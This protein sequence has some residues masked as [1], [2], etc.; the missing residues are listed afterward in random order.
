MNGRN[1]YVHHIG[2][3]ILRGTAQEVTSVLFWPTEIGMSP[4]IVCFTFI[5]NSMLQT[6]IHMQQLI[7]KLVHCCLYIGCT[8]VVSQLLSPNHETLAN[9]L[10]VIS[11]AWT[12]KQLCHPDLAERTPLTFIPPLSEEWVSHEVMVIFPGDTI[13]G[14][15]SAYSMP[16]F[17]G[18]F[19]AY[20]FDSSFS[21]QTILTTLFVNSSQQ[22]VRTYLCHLGCV[23]KYLLGNLQTSI[24]MYLLPAIC[25]CELKVTYFG[26]IW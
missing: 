16:I 14:M 19:Q 25:R 5:T 22:D 13:S 4:L 3:A 2:R 21:K 26:S 1:Q 10:M 17:Q 9:L 7:S 11:M 8:E 18:F 6:Q 24:C 12:W 23:R 15:G 20:L